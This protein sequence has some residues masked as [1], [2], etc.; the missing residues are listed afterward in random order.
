MSVGSVCEAGFSCKLHSE[1]AIVKTQEH[2]Q[3][4]GWVSGKE[5]VE[6]HL[7]EGKE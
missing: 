7:R 5:L 4:G 6:E 3:G 1:R 2:G